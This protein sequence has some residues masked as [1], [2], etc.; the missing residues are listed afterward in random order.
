MIRPTMMTSAAVLLLF[1]GAAAMAQRNEQRDAPSAPSQQRPDAG[2]EAPG[3]EP[4]D[5]RSEVQ[6]K[7]A[8]KGEAASEKSSQSQTQERAQDR[9]QGSTQNQ[10]QDRGDRQDR[11]KGATQSRPDGK[12][13]PKARAGKGSEP[14]T[15]QQSQ[16]APQKDD[17]GDVRRG[18]A[19]AEKSSE[20]KAKSKSS[21]ETAPE[22]KAKGKDKAATSSEP[23]AKRARES[24]ESAAGDS[25]PAGGKAAQNDGTNEKEGAAR[26]EGKVQI[27]EQQRRTVRENLFKNRKVNRADN[28]RVTV[29]I[30]SRLPR[31]VKL[32]PL[33]PSIVSIVPAYRRYEYV[34]VDNRI[35]IVEPATYEIV[36]VLDESSTRVTG[37]TDG[38][39]LTLTREEQAIVFREIEVRSRNTLG[40]GALTAG[41]GVPPGVD[42][43]IFPTRV[44]ER[45]PKLRNYRYFSADNRVA[46]VDPEGRNIVFL[47]EEN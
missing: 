45:V 28:V 17:T 31:S 37:R 7:Q 16:D 27:S 9:A 32:A 36:Q 5:G 22:P 12:A 39:R 46:I 1:G 20:P 26:S 21:A 18:K 23:N 29:N 42:I 35:V 13:E 47:V 34:V 8:P 41:A 33:P 2:R 6:R 15:Q 19:K 24:S 14:R 25:R 3:K 43:H 38:G 11:T 4:G 40:L 30:G 10:A 44:V